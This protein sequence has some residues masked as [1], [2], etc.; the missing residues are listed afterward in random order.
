MYSLF[1]KILIWNTKTTIDVFHFSKIGNFE[2]IIKEKR[3]PIF[4][5][6]E[7]RIQKQQDL[8]SN[9]RKL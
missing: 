2:Y 1:R 6:H 5:K 7:S 4:E 3:I 9:F 8:Y